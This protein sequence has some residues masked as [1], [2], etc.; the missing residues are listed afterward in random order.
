MG[1]RWCWARRSTS[2]HRQDTHTYTHYTAHHNHTQSTKRTQTPPQFPPPHPSLPPSSSGLCPDPRGPDPGGG[3]HGPRGVGLFE[4]G[5]GQ[6]GQ[7]G[8]VPRHLACPC[9]SPGAHA[10]PTVPRALRLPRYRQTSYTGTQ[11]QSTRI[12]TDRDSPQLVSPLIPPLSP[13]LCVQW[14]SRAARCVC[15]ATRCC[16]T[17]CSWRVGPVP[18]PC[19]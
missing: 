5:G 1:V 3:D 11:T 17:R 13:S 8:V 12:E 9:A 16:S 2:R 6:G 7:A 18:S 4:W 15:T 14:P 19:R 10:H